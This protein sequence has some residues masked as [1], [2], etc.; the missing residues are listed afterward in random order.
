MMSQQTEPIRKTE[1]LLKHKI[2]SGV[3]TYSDQI[4]LEGFHT[5]AEPPAERVSKFKERSM[6]MMSSEEEREKEES[7]TEKSMEISLQNSLKM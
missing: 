5:R 3:R 7:M 4:S 6:E 1:K 2:K